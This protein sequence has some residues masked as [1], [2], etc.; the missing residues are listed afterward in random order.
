MAR[1]DFVLFNL[2]KNKTS[3]KSEDKGIADVR[4]SEPRVEYSHFNRSRSIATRLCLPEH[5]EPKRL[6][7]ALKT[8]LSVHSVAIKL[9]VPDNSLR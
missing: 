2:A 4:Q 8:P 6:N 1:Q 3:K 5:K 9:V 7:V